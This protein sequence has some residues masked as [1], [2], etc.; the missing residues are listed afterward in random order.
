MLRSLRTSALRARAPVV[1]RI[2]YRPLAVASTETFGKGHS[3]LPPKSASLGSFLDGEPSK[4]NV[5]T[6]IPGP[7]TIAAKEA[8]GKLQDVLPSP[9]FVNVRSEL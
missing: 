2:F 8:M 1:P 5:T 9:G 6:N 7:K 3:P 4:P